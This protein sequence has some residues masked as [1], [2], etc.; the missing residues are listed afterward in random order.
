MTKEEQFDPIKAGQQS[1]EEWRNELRQ[2]PDYD[3]IYQEEAAKSELCLQLVEAQ[4]E[5]GLTRKFVVR[6]SKPKLPRNDRL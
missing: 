1:Y 6:H 4:Q 2:N 5:T 3:E